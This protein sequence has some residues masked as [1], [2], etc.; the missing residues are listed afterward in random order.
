ME[1]KEPFEQ[2][3]A[4]CALGQ[5][6]ADGGWEAIPENRREVFDQAH[7]RIHH[8][9]IAM[10]QEA[11]Q[12]APGAILDMIWDI[13]DASDD[14]SSTLLEVMDQT[15]VEVAT[16]DALTGLPNRRS[17]ER[18]Y[19]QAV[20][21]ARRYRLFLGLHLLDIDLF[22]RINDTF[23]HLKGDEV[24][25]IFSRTVKFFCG[26]KIIFIAGAVKSLQL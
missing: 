10:L 13:E 17:F 4:K 7:K 8:L 22:K 1:V 12:G 21:M 2:D 16:R 15:F 23:G 24:L 20:K 14:V 3:P 25:R 9:G 11:Q 19:H 26:V 6:L 18:D 5:W